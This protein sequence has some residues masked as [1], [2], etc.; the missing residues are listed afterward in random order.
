MKV[1]DLQIQ[2]SYRQVDP[3]SVGK[4]SPQ[5]RRSEEM[6][7]SS[8]SPSF[9]DIFQEKLNEEQGIRFS[10][11]ALQRIEERNLMPSLQSLE[12]LNHGVQQVQEKGGRSSLILVDDTAFVV[13][14]KNKTVVTAI[15]RQNA[16]DQVFTNIDSVAIV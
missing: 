4:S 16:G 5:T 6:P 2:N 7:G 8:Q 12:R 14:V 10:A 11:H 9:S 15:D 3:A 1:A 13:S